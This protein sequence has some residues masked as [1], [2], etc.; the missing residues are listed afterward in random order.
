MSQG[1]SRCGSKTADRD[2]QVLAG[3]SQSPA[4]V[5]LSTLSSD[6]VAGLGGQR[7]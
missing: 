6:Q 1:W 5:P 3:R 2:L 4:S 7:Y